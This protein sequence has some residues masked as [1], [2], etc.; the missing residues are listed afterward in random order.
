MTA[1]VVVILAAGQGT[2]MRSEVPKLL[3]P[4]C[5][6][7]IIEWTIAAARDAGAGTIVLVDS[8]ERQLEFAVAD[9]V[10][11]AVQEQPL[12][13]ADAV[14]AALGEIG[15]GDTVIVVNGDAPLIQPEALRALV[16]THQQSGAA[17]TIATMVL[18]DPRG[19]GRVVRAPDGTVE[20]VV[21][22]KAPG[23]AT[24]LELH[25]R[26]VST[27]LFAF[28]GGALIS[29]LQEVRADN[30]QGEHYLP[31]VL[32]IVRRHERTVGAYELEDADELLGINDRRQLA[33][34]TA[35][36]QRMIHERLMLAGVTI[37]NP[38]AT[39][40]DHGV[41]IGRDTVV[42]PFTSLHG[43]TAIGEDCTVGPGSTLIDAQVGHRATILHSYVTGATI[44]DRVS[45]GPFAYLRP[46]TILR[47]GSKA[48]TFVEIKNSDV[49][50]GTK[51]PHLSYIGDAE[52]GEDTNLG[53][54]TITANYD[55]YR[56]NRTW[57][58]HRVRTSVDTTLIAPVTVGDDAYT[59][60]GSVI[61]TDVPPG[62]LGVARA[63]QTNIDGYAE[64]RRER[65]AAEGRDEAAVTQAPAGATDEPP[66]ATAPNS[67][68]RT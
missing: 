25:I 7:P 6:R 44:G 41:T 23:D 40:I 38:G 52:I 67:G 54:S 13:T 58:G 27:G 48:G 51:V 29:A 20:R 39:V 24:E 9:G 65:A 4:L 2:R 46:G 34:V 59:A 63:R 14:K 21:E 33:E 53:A 19:Y 35:I 37:V 57:I 8:P 30:A 42:A 12:G 60:A 31:D 10:V 5:G 36:A 56:K 55:G 15:A 43:A 49:G 17:A 68:D 32:P 1:P 11:L 22:T 61:S 26:E 3:H 50:R 28:E 47:E 18:E 45:V 64:R 66:P 62:A 16:D